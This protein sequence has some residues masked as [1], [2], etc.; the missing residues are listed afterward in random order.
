MHIRDRCY[1]F[2]NIFA[3]KNRQKFAFLTQN[4]AKFCKNLIITLFFL[5]KTQYF[6]RKSQKIVIIIPGQFTLSIAMFFP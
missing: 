4:K 3:K 6:Q 5:R 2:K 1:G